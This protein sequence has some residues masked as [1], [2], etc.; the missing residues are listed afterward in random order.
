MS[1]RK[2]DV[3]IIGAGFTGLAAADALSRAGVEFAVLEARD[4]VGGRVEAHPNTLGERID[5]GGQFLCEDMPEILALT[6]E[7]GTP[8]VETPV[9]GDFIVQPRVP[10]A[11]GERDYAASMALRDRMAALDPYDPAIRDLHVGEWLARQ[12]EGPAAKWGFHSMVEGLWCRPIDE[13]PLWYLI[14][15]DRRITNE[16]YELQYFP[17][18]TMHG[19]AKGLAARLGE[20][21]LLETP[22]RSVDL[23]AESARLCTD[24]DEWEAGGVIVA[25]PP[26]AARGIEFNG[27]LPAS[28]RNALVAWK[29]G[30]VIK[31]FLRYEHAFWRHQGLNGMVMWRE[32]HGLFACDC[33][34]SATAPGLVVFVAGPLAMKV[35]LMGEDQATA[36]LVERL[37]EAL[38]VQASKPLDVTLRDWT[39]DPWSGGGYSDVITDMGAHDAE[40]I[41]RAGFGTVVF[42]SSELSP[43]FPGYVEGAII[44][45]RNAAADV[46]ERLRHSS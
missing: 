28:I 45:G 11:E 18:M 42:A 15:N 19:V 22:V 10:V 46:I 21:L 39:D 24:K 13:I 27:K 14:S 25:V 17:A 34:H 6:R 1:V 5:T 32:M 9:E 20:R 16:V 4:R 29:S 8:L 3:V 36:W 26:V 33:S 43:S 2:S 30:V 44:A 40:D 23:S 38:G 37:V 31:A 7:L 41:L 35:H 12:P